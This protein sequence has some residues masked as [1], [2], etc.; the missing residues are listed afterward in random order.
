MTRLHSDCP[1]L[2]HDLPHT[3]PTVTHQ[4]VEVVGSQT[5][6][7]DVSAS[8]LTIEPVEPEPSRRERPQSAC[9]GRLLFGQ[10][11]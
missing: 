4:I 9:W 1:L 7:A 10:D 5:T 11:G 2:E 6:L 8:I 3:R